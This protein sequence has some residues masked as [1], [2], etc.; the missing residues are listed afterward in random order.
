MKYQERVIAPQLIVALDV[1]TSREIAYIAEQLPAEIMWY[2]IG[3][4][5]F[6]AEGPA[7]LDALRALGKN[8]F[9]D[10]KLHDIPRTV[11]RAVK[12]ATQ[13]GVHMLTVHAAGGRS[14]LQA[15]ADAAQ[16]FGPN[17]PTLL[18]VTA[19]T[20]LDQNDLDDLGIARTLEAHALKMA[21]L[22][23]GAGIPGLVCSPQ[24][25]RKLRAE[26]GTDAI[27]VTPG[28]RLSSGAASDQKRVGSPRDAARDGSNFLV[29]GRPILESSSPR[30]AAE[31]ILREI[32]DAHK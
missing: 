32:S 3:L 17:A 22:A 27:L 16:S 20:S 14:M 8:I 9:L 11:E 30:A 13:H 1:S 2:K 15:A 25:I 31:T 28:I 7:S 26:F 19:L 24:E 18:A 4:E 5:L 23:L 29:V 21:E 12:S 10:L 6:C